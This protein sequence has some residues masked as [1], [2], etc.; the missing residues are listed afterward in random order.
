MRK[1]LL[2]IGSIILIAAL[3]VGLSYLGFIKPPKLVQSLPVVGKLVAK[4]TQ[5]AAKTDAALGNPLQNRIKFLEEEVEKQQAEI[6][7]LQ[8]NNQELEKKST[9]SQTDAKAKQAQI[10]QLQKQQAD[11]KQLAKYYAGMKKSQAAAIMANLDD[12]TV[13]GIL[14]NMDSETAAAIMGELDPQR[15]AMIT[16]QMLQ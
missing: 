9:A 13:I 1:V 7:K 16:Q 6:T 11:Y 12:A 2:A 15:A 4:K 3:L 5:P 8:S 10:D 14:Q